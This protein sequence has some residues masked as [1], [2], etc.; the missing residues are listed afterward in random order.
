MISENKL[1]LRYSVMLR[2]R[3][4]NVN[5]D[6]NHDDSALLVNPFLR[7]RICVVVGHWTT[8]DDRHTIA[9]GNLHIFAAASGRK[10]SFP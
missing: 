5:D 6:W 10:K 1:R 2:L 9:T 7:I 3:N 8:A 4:K